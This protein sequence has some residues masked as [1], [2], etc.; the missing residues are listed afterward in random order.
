MTVYIPEL[1]TRFTED[2]IVL[3]AVFA[4]D[5]VSIVGNI[6]GLKDYLER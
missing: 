6:M 3:V 2:E 5:A 1:I 4:V